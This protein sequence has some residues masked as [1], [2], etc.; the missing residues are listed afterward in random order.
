MSSDPWLLPAIPARRADLMSL[1]ISDPRQVPVKPVSDSL[2][3]PATFGIVA[4]GFFFVAIIGWAAVFE[5]ASAVQ[6]IAVTR[7]ARQRHA[8]HYT[9]GGIVTEIL[10][11]ESDLVEQGQVLI[12]LDDTMAKANLPLL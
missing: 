11:K 5:I 12:R 4:I 8:V 7:A 6:G 9:H 10:I 1:V 2:R 3:G